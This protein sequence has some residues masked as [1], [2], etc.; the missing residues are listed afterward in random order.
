MEF[1]LKIKTKAT[2][3]VFFKKRVGEPAATHST[4]VSS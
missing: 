4:L 1:Y 2:I 3:N